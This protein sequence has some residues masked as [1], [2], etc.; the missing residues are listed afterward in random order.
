MDKK[1]IGA[2]LK[3]L[4]EKKGRTQFQVM[5]DLFDY[6]IVISDKTIAK[7]EKG[8]FPDLDTLA[9]VAD[10][11]GVKSSDILNG[12]IYEPQNL[13]KRYFIVNNTWLSENNANN[14]Y[15]MRIEQES[16][17]KCRVKELLLLLIN[18]KSLTPMQNDELNFLLIH[19]YSIS[20]YATQM[21][22]DLEDLN[23]REQVK[24]LR[25]K[26]YRTILSMHDS[27]VDEIYWEIKKLYNYDKRIT[28]E[29]DV[30]NF[31]DNIAITSQRLQELEDWE[32]DLLL[33]QVQTNNINHVYGINSKLTYLK[34]FG[35][36][37]DEERI[38]KEGIK[39]LIECGAKLNRAL[40]GYTK[41]RHFEFSI[42]ERMKLLH[43]N[44]YDKILAPQYDAE[45]LSPKYYWIENNTK[46]RLI[47][48]YYA[49]NCS[50]D[51]KLTLNEIHKMFLANGS[52]P[53][54]IILSRYQHFD[55]KPRS[56][57][58]I[59]LMAE[60]LC[61][62]EIKLWNE[63]KEKELGLEEAKKELATLE[64]R[65]ARGERIDV[66]EYDEWVGEEEDKLT[67]RDIIL[68]FA[69]MSYEQFVEGRD[70]TLTK[71]LLKNLDTMSL[72]KI[73]ERYFPVEVRY[74]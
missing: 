21:Y 10:Y 31:E 24:L 36:D 46:N 17:I 60:Q 8:N 16:L 38:T 27:A 28:F 52:L 14:L 4:R 37:Y 2:F 66:H 67:E 41:H 70:E 48:L 1:K 32:K 59:L 11:Y 42:L 3:S 29:K 30:C 6:G 15:M 40:L 63:C 18:E 74:E 7:W 47:N 44:I 73:R 43:N 35:K 53:Q 50:R 71:E 65:W 45:S 64:G 19:F 34:Q 72:S 54:E 56:E 9:K 12:E 39:L 51:E 26:I 55:N 23:K 69:N 49:L 33:A 20:S 13:E 25:H 57:K 58:E 61:P 68:R 62:Y 22:S 5:Q